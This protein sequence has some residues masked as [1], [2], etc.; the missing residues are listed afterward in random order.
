MG[1]LI[2]GVSSIFLVLALLLA[3]SPL[4]AK[5]CVSLFNS[6]SLNYSE[7]LPLYS[8]LE[9][10]ENAKG[11]VLLIHGLGDNL[12]HLQKI[13]ESLKKDGYSVLRVDLHGHGK[14]LENDI[15]HNKPIP[16]VIP[17]ENNVKDIIEVIKSTGFENPIVIG[18]SYG[19]AIAYSVSNALSGQYKARSLIMLAPYLRRLDHA[20]LTGN[21]VIDMQTEFMTEQFM[22]TTYRDYFESQKREHIDEQINGAIATTKGIRRF[23]IL[24]Y[25][26]RASPQVK[27]PLLVIGGSKDELIKED[28]IETL[29]QKLLSENYAH[30]T[31]LIEGDHFFPQKESKKTV[32][33]IRFFLKK[34]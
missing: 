28:Q 16:H 32:E 11:N 1:Y 30:E 2:V 5:T 10:V 34:K 7:K 17:Y 21:P 12:T 29:H 22:R 31:L 27:I 3:Q 15:V 33:A 6:P 9:K 23:D 20:L 26:K 18:H 24:S 4:Q 14:N 8:K 13:S 25:D 19:G